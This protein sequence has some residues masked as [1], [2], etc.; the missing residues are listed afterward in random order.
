VAD[1]WLTERDDVYTH[2][3]GAKWVNIRALAGNDTVTLLTGSNVLGGAG[4][5]TIIDKTGGNSSAALY[6]DSPN[7][8]DVNLVTGVAKDGWG[9]TDKLVAI[10]NVHTSGRNGDRVIG[11]NLDDQTWINGFGSQGTC[12]IDLSLG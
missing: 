2:V 5:D 10:R 4:N 9:T 7:A 12:Y 6:W 1:I 3:Q 11:S 8:I